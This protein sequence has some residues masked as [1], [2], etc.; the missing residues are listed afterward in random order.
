MKVG[1]SHVFSVLTQ[2]SYCVAFPGGSLS[3]PVA[4]IPEVSYGTMVQ[5][6]TLTT[7]VLLEGTEQRLIPFVANILRTSLIPKSMWVSYLFVLEAK[8]TRSQKNYNCF[9]S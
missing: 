6:E 5:I 2:C 8:D 4:R 7:Q 3:C 1:L 9:F